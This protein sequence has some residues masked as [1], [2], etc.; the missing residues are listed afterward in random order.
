VKIFAQLISFSNPLRRRIFPFL[1]PIFSYSISISTHLFPFTKLKF[2]SLDKISLWKPSNSY[3]IL[4]SC[5]D[6]NCI[7]EIDFHKQLNQRYEFLMKK[8]KLGFPNCDIPSLPVVPFANPLIDEL[9]LGW[10]STSKLSLLFLYEIY[11]ILTSTSSEKFSW[12]ASLVDFNS[13]RGFWLT[14]IDLARL[15]WA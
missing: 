2:L 10:Q 11:E 15:H 1:S 8:M 14:K 3:N 7:L 5:K 9:T 4:T 6:T 13:L 12:D